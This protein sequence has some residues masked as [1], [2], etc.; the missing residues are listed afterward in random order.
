MRVELTEVEHHL[1]SF[2][3]IRQALAAVH[4]DKMNQQH[5][6]AYLSPKNIDTKQL[7]QHVAKFLPM[8]MIP[9]S[10]V[11]LDQFPK[12][13]NGKADRDSLPEPQY[14]DFAEADYVAPHGDM[15][16]AV[17]SSRILCFHSFFMCSCRHDAHSTASD[18]ATC[19]HS[20]FAYK[21]KRSCCKTVV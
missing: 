3:G 15:Q 13:P 18:V 5:L 2:P 19:L 1:S 11:L 12:M 4:T 17:K 8:P 14:S 7:R 21:T 16:Q 6:V 9:E 10:F 20:A